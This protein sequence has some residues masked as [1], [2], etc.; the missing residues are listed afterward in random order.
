MKI[1]LLGDSNVGKTEIREKYLGRGFQS[2]YM[3][4][5]GAD[6]ALKETLINGKAIKFR[7][8]HLAGQQQ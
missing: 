6:F 1:C 8:W 2:K 7:I 3:M 5:I 4:T